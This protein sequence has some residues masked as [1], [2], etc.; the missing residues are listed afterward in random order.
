MSNS[1]N[2]VP[3]HYRSENRDAQQFHQNPCKIDVPSYYHEKKQPMDQIFRTL[4][5]S[6]N[7]SDWQYTE[8]SLQKALG[9]RVEQERTK[10][11]YYKIERLNRV[12][13]LLKVASAMKL[14]S[15]LIPLLLGSQTDAS[16][17]LP[18]PMTTPV[19]PGNETPA[20]YSP[21]L[22]PSPLKGEHK[23]RRTV[24]SFADLQPLSKNSIQNANDDTSD[25]NIMKSFKFGLGSSSPSGIQKNRTSLPPKHQLSPSRVGARAVSSLNRNFFSRPSSLM[26]LKHGKR[27]QRTLSLPMNVTIPETKPMVFHT[28]ATT[29]TDTGMTVREIHIPDFSTSTSKNTNDVDVLVNRVSCHGEHNVTKNSYIKSPLREVATLNEHDSASATYSDQ[30][31]GLNSDDNVLEP[32]TP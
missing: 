20:T 6:T 19:N 5:G 10:Q 17:I 12:I 7:V 24:S 13:E 22:S 28:Q 32:K 4:F 16:T 25:L 11:E 18:T 21:D 14:P 23:H 3:E 26:E 27:H 15:H 1:H 29:T 8:D 2:S 30:S 9:V 31:V